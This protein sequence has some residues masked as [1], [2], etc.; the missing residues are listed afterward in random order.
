M[1][2]IY[3]LI[4]I[5]VLLTSIGIYIFLW[6]VKTEQFDDLEKQALSILFDDPKDLSPQTPAIKS[7]ENIQENSDSANFEGVKPTNH[8]H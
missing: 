8:D 5:A 6:A 2:V 4:P 7:E 1:S 3:V